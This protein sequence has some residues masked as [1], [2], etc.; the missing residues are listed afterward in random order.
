MRAY[1]LMIIALLVVFQGRAQQ[2]PEG[3]LTEEEKLMMLSKLWQEVNYNFAYFDQVKELDWDSL[4]MAYMP[5][6]KAAETHYEL[7]RELSAFLAAL[8]DGHTTML[9]LPYFREMEV[10]PM[11]ELKPI[12]QKVYVTNAGKSLDIPLGSEVLAVN[13]MPTVEYL[14]TEVFPYLASSTEHVLW[15]RGVGYMLNGLKSETV[16]LRLQT[17]KGKVIE[18][19]LSREESKDEWQMERAAK[20]PTEFKWLKRDVAYFAINTFS[21]DQVFEDFQKHL[22]D[23]YKSKA[24]ILDIR[25][26][27]GGNGALAAKIASYF[28]QAD[29][30]Y[31]SKWKTRKHVA[32]YKAW[33][34][35]DLKKLGFDPNPDYAD[36]G[37]MQVWHQDDVNTVAVDKELKRI[38]VPF[39]MLTSNAT[40]SAAEDFLIYTDGIEKRTVIGQKTNGSTGQPVI[41]TLHD[42]YPFWAMICTKR[43]TY[44]D[45]RDFVGIGIIPD[46]EV[47]NTLDDLMGKTD[48]VLEAAIEYLKEKS[49]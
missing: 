23:F 40:V 12:G 18:K 24:V 28:T 3:K 39:V 21:T 29:T 5:K 17:P 45:G 15:Q 38:K 6:V 46:I 43:D 49:L 33:G 1:L 47:E 9:R 11:L 8:K 27:N 31:G 13:N 34:T 32:T 16:S 2:K 22:P 36:Y 30:L 4:Y 14:Q 7:Y 20:V 35:P 42:E 10:A 44:P 48:S 19:T 25:K 37:A 26:N 41:V